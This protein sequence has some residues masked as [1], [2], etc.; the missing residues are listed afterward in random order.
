MSGE[1]TPSEGSV[2]KHPHCS[3]GLYHQHSADILE[4]DAPL[5]GFM[6]KQFPPAVVKKTD[7]WWR[8]YLALFGFSPEQQTSPIGTLSLTLAEPKPSP[9]SRRAQSA[10]SP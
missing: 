7:E 8:G 10:R 1:L 5:L 2:K 9:S 4:L 6:R 3:L